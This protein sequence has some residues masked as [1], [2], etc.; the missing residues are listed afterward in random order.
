MTERPRVAIA[1][2][3][4]ESNAFCPPFRFTPEEASSTFRGEEILAD[5]RSDNPRVHKEVSGFVRRM[6]ERTD[7]E[8]LS[9]LFAGMKPAGPAD[10]S[11]VDAYLEEIL[12]ALAR[13]GRLD[14][15]YIANHGAMTA[16]QDED[17]EGTIA[18]RI[19]EA[20]G[21]VPVVATLDLHGNISQRHVDS[22]DL[23]VSYREDPHYDQYRTGVEC[24]DGLIEILSGTRT[25]LANLRLPIVPPNVSLATDDGPYGEVIAI[26]Q[27]M[28]DER[29]MN[30][31]V[32]AG[33]AFSD[34]SKNG[35][36]V[37]VTARRDR[38]PQGARAAEIAE[39]VAQAAWDRKA[40]FDWN[41]TAME[42][43]VNAAVAVG[44]DASQPPLLL[45]DLGDN[46][47]AGG[48][49]RSLWMLRALHEAGA[50]DA[51][52]ACLFDPGVVAQA[53]R[54]GI[55]GEFDAV[56][57]GDD[58]AGGPARYAARAQVVALA[59]GR[60]IAR[61]G[62]GKG[63]SLN[64]GESCLLRCGPTLVMATSRHTVMNDPAYVEMM[65]IKPG[66]FRSI[67]LK[68][69]GSSYRKAWGDY[70]PEG[71]ENLFVDTPGRTSPVLD[72]FD[73]K[74]LPRPVWPIDRDATW[75]GAKAAVRT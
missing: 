72:R 69:R 25:V 13:A 23:A 28:M 12:A 55:G 29:I 66:S 17:I 26:G 27:Q 54:A 34:T 30:V 64:A 65:G 47:G 46:A 20:V 60:C 51:L 74:R 8:P 71:R 67:V 5:A 45:V 33:F 35:I 40:R 42:D 19:R 59:D 44:D 62:I 43:A 70:F 21:D 49:A 14:A 31:S 18:A 2:I 61:R 7:W 32:L 53:W 4:I 1:G 73:W 48:S 16:T 37:I 58:W 10:Q 6:D 38:D 39:A 50:K 75:A 15:V 52:V 9:I 63:R 41:L 11:K 22:L 36:H 24:A 57:T 56:F 3:F 68:G